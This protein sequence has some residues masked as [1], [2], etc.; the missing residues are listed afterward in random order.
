MAIHWT[1]QAANIPLNIN[2]LQSYWWTSFRA[3]EAVVSATCSEVTEKEN[4]KNQSDQYTIAMFL[5][6]G[7]LSMP[8][9]MIALELLMFLHCKKLSN[10]FSSYSQHILLAYIPAV[11]I[12][13]KS[14]L[15]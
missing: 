14:P 9:Q 7:L 12:R 3:G 10:I 8:L 15:N 2:F 1:K 4:G 13:Q 6:R 5:F 11:H